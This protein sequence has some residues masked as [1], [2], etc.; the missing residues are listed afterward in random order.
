[1][2]KMSVIAGSGDMGRFPS[3]GADVTT[4]PLPAADIHLNP[5][6]PNSM[7]ELEIRRFC[8]RIGI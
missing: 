1:M 7:S 3:S 6:N 4:G 8:D 2:T 5:G